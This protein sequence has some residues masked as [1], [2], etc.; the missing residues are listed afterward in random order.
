MKT[1]ILFSILFSIVAL[2][3]P[4]S[5]DPAN[6]VSNGSFEAS[7]RKPGVP[8]D[9]SAAG[10]ASVVQRLDLDAGRDGNRAARLTCTSFAGDTPD[11]HVMICQVGR[12]SVRRGQWYRL[13]FWAKA[14]RIRA[15]FVDV[16]LSDTREWANTGLGEAFSPPARWERFEFR[17]RA[18]RD[19]PAAASRLQFWFKG[20]GTLWLDDVSLAETEG[21]QEWFPQIPSD[22]AK[23]LVPN[24][25]FE[26]GGANWGSFTYGLAGWAGNLYRLE[27]AI[28]E[29]A[30][31]HGRHSLRIAL[32]PET[33][34]IFWFDYYEPVRQPVRRVLVANR[35]W[36]RVAPGERMTL[37]AWLRADPPGAGAEFIA[38]EAGG[39]QHR[40]AVTAGGEWTR[41][42]FTFAPS[43][44]FL[45]IAVGLDLEATRRESATLWIDAIQLERGDRAADYAPRAAVES[46]I[47]TAA[48]GNLFV[49]ED[50]RPVLTIRAYN[51]SPDEKTARG[52]LSVTDF[53]DRP[54]FAADPRIRLSPRSAG[55]LT[56]DDIVKGRR[57][58]FRAT[59]ASGSAPPQALRFARIDPAGAEAADGP[60]GFNHA[61]PWDFLVRLAGA[62]GVGW[63]RDWSAKWQTIEPEK[64]KLDF[65]VPDAQI[66]RVLDLGGRA[67]VLLPFPSA[68]WSTTADPAVVE[69]AAGRDAYLRSRMPLAFAPKDL[70]DF[71]AYAAR[72]VEHYAP[73]GVRA[74]GI[75]N[76]PIYTS[77]ALPRRFG[78]TLD[79]YLRLLEA[80]HA[81]MKRADPD[82]LIIGGIAA[83]A[84][85]GLTREFVAK[86]GLRL[87]DVLDLHLY[88]PARPAESHEESLAALENL[89]REHGGAKPIWVTEWGCY[90]DDDPPCIPHSFGDQTMNRCLWRSE[91]AAAE[92]IVKFAA[93]SFAHG[94]RKLF[95]HAGTC[96][97]INGTDAGGVLFEYGGTPRKML[98]AVAALTRILGTPDAFVGKVER[99]D[100]VATIFRS[101]GRQV[102]IA[103]AGAGEV[104][105]AIGPDVR[106]FDIQGNEISGAG[107]SPAE[108]PIGETPVYLIGPDVARIL[109]R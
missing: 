32:S 98:P 99:E 53:F 7:A 75:L 46:F 38:R 87:V 100:L 25:S 63:W 102:A 8:D 64:G 21:G 74:Y 66:L 26:C 45:F 107:T 4:A 97:M 36:F 88:G 67:E 65:A 33:L 108:I 37:S 31:H 95:F 34:P 19:L 6:L 39:R 106:A 44:A 59:W 51:D 27:G 90:A 58:F 69:K 5:P 81:A 61:Y 14:E 91:R 89:M 109:A 3:S 52:T 11:A 12:V 104:R 40:R 79:D 10:N 72:V 41:H 23:N 60:F 93:V 85:A 77:Y 71:G 20:T 49:G 42:A 76:E 47:E 78:Y 55:S 18:T 105:L 30:A 16:A 68:S 103:W 2:A 56:L 62:A 80:A 101:R 94:I 35:G 15:G 83:G 86:G 24:S 96:G 50:P 13:E 48:E 28:D 54:V 70:G 57:G 92:H 84:D 29:T 43:E 82:C 17:F 9:W 1:T 22:G 73:R